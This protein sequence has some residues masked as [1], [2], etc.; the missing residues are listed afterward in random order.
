[1]SWYEPL[2]CISKS[3][4]LGRAICIITALYVHTLFYS[5]HTTWC[6]VCVLFSD[7]TLHTIPWNLHRWTCRILGVKVSILVQLLTQISMFATR[8][9]TFPGRLRSFQTLICFWPVGPH[10]FPVKKTQYISHGLFRRSTKSLQ[11]FLLLTFLLM[12]EKNLQDSVNLV[13]K[14]FLLKIFG[15]I[16]AEV[17]TF[18]WWWRKWW[19]VFGSSPQVS[20]TYKNYSIYSHPQDIYDMDRASTSSYCGTQEQTWAGIQPSTST[21]EDKLNMY[22]FNENQLKHFIIKCLM[23]WH[24]L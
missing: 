7:S 19:T 17:N 10:N 18:E 5:L 22:K 13:H 12:W 16:S 24:K 21:W 8:V 3:P 11:S 1:M 15:V 9:L 6:M 14:I 23:M 2:Q 20:D 4:R